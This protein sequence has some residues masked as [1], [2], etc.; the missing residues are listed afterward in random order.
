MFGC[1]PD[2]K[3]EKGNIGYKNNYA[4]ES[5]EKGKQAKEGSQKKID[6]FLRMYGTLSKINSPSEEKQE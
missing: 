1:A 5:E 6:K 4:L 2:K 3:K